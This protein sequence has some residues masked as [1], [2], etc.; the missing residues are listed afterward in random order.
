M[1][2]GGRA[3][4]LAALVSGR[5]VREGIPP[6]GVWEERALEE[7]VE[8]RFSFALVRGLILL[9]HLADGQ[10]AR[11]KDLATDLNLSASTARTYVRTLLLAGLVE[12]DSTT[13]L[14]RLAR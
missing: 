3:V 8:S 10:P 7:T 11:L 4:S 2:H 6:I 1:A 13:R 9:A 14:Y 5:A 12:Q